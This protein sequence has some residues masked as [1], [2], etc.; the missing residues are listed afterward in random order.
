MQSVFDGFEDDYERRKERARKAQA[1]QSS[2]GREIGPL[3]EVPDEHKQTIEDCRLDLRKFLETFL[4]ALFP[5]KWSEAHLQAIA[6]LQDV[7]LN[8]G[9]FA[10]AMARG[11]GKT[12]LIIGAIIWAIVYGHRRFILAVAATGPLAE[13]IAD[14]VKTI[15]ETYDLLGVCFPAACY[16]VRKLDGINN[17][18]SGQTLNKERTRIRWTAKRLVFPTVPGAASS[19]VRLRAAGILSA[20]R[21]M[22]LVNPE[23]G[24]VERPDFCIA[25][26]PQTDDS[27]KTPEQTRKRKRIVQKVLLKLAGPKKKIAFVC[28]CTIIEPDDLAA[29]LLDREKHP[30]LRGRITRLLTR[31]PDETAMKHW[32]RYKEIRADSLREHEDIRLATEYYREHHALMQAGAEVS[33]PERFEPGQLD[34]LQ[35][36]MDQWAA[37]EDS[38]FAEFQNDPRRHEVAGIESLR[39]SELLHRCDG[40]ERGQVPEWAT[41]LTAFADVQQDILPWMVIAWGENLRGRIVDYGAWPKQSKRYYTLR[42]LSPTLREAT[43]QPTVESAIEVGLEALTRELF[44]RYGES[45]KCFG[46]D[47]NWPVSTAI[48]YAASRRHPR[49]MPFHGRFVGAASLP[50]SAWKRKPGERQGHFWRTSMEQ[51]ARIITCDSN[52]WKTL[53]MKRLQ[54]SPERGITWFGSKPHLHEQLCDELSA[55]YAV[56]VTGRGRKVDEWKN[57]PGRENHLFDCVV[58]CAVCASFAGMEMPGQQATPK[59]KKVRGSERQRERRASRGRLR[60]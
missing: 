25:D 19:G 11:T 21:G 7:V 42:D 37:D 41:M 58:G 2:K 17:R 6:T 4:N 15:I 36:G 31:M 8:G 9:Q 22:K 51:S 33:W 12:T 34:A 53:V 46:V 10:Y 54:G 57:R 32:E 28:P 45:L 27:A 59:A 3:P 14:D 1:E 48:V 13:D 23:T 16:P 56:R 52:T 35:F 24:E 26:D 5:L 47:A 29:Q 55:E 49:L 20:G 44:E 60:G 30:E 40:S 50:M 39:A 18:S 38:F 43:E